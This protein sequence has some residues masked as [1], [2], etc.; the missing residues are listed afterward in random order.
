MTRKVFFLV[1]MVCSLNV[2]AQDSTFL[3]RVV[4]SAAVQPVQEKVYLHL[5]KPTYYAGDTIWY[6]A[7]TVTSS[8][9]RL[10]PLSGVLYAELIGPKDSVI[11]RQTL[12]LVAGIAWGEFALPRRAGIYHV[13]AY[14]NWM[15]NTD[16]SYFFNQRIMVLGPGL[17]DARLSVPARQVSGKKPDEHPD[18]QFLPE[19]GSLVVGLRSR[20]AGRGCQRNDSRQ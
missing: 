3:S 17:A 20:V 12:K 15:R 4:S 8:G 16:A 19:G 2:Y 6:K 18:I 13:R 10:S 9:H 7:Y 14:T 11:S 5:N 1:L